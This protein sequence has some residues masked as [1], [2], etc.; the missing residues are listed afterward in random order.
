MT[1][2]LLSA[3]FWI[4]GP[5][6]FL[7]AVIVMLGMALWFPVGAADINNI[8]I[9]LVLFPALWAGIFFFAYLEP[10]L[11]RVCFVYALLGFPNTALIAARFWF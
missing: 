9:P 6:C 1:S 11:M 10:R 3:R 4:C 8:V 7:L 2:T 5:V